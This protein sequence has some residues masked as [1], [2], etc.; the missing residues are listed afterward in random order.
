MILTREILKLVVRRPIIEVVRSRLFQL[1]ALGLALLAVVPAAATTIVPAADPG[2]LALDSE[3]VFLARAGVSRVVARPGYLATTTELEVVS[4]AKGSMSPGSVI[5]SIVPGGVKDG[6]GWVVAGAPKLES[7]KVYLFFAD[8]DPRGRW[9][10]RLMADSVLRQ[11]IAEDGSKVL[12]PLEEASHLSRVGSAGRD[13]PLVPG[14]VNEEEFIAAL[15]RRLDGKPGWDWAPL[16]RSGGSDLYAKDAPAGCV[17]M[18]HDAGDGRP[19]R[20]RLFDSGGTQSMA[21]DS[22]G[23]SSLSSGGFAQVQGA[24]ARWN[25]VT[26]T[27]VSVSYGG[28]SASPP[29]S[30]TDDTDIT[31]NAV[32]FDDPCNEMADLTGCSGTLAFGGPSFYSTTTYSWD[33]QQWHQAISWFVVVNN[34]AGN[35]LSLADY[36]LMLTHEM[37]HGLGFGHVSDP[38]AL[39]HANCC[40]PHNSLDISCT[41]YLYPTAASTP[42]PTRTPTRTATPSG[43]TPTPTPTPPPGTTP[44]RTPAPQPTATPTGAT[45]TP[46]PTPSDSRPSQVTVPVVIHGE[47]VEGTP[48]RSDVVV[49]NP[50]SSPQELRFI[51][52][53]SGKAAFSATK[54]LAGRATLL[55]EDLVADL[56]RAGDSRGPL[57]IEVLTPGSEAPVV[58]SRAY[59]ENPF[60]NLG[61]GLPADV[62]PS[63]DVVS[64]PG[65]FHDEAFRSNIAVTADNGHDVWATFELFRGMDDLVGGG[66]Q[67]LIGAGQ[68][69]QWSIQQLFKNQAR[70]GVPMTV[71]VSLSHPGIVNASMID[72]LSTDSA[73]FLGKV[74]AINWIVPVVAHI[75]GSDGTFWNSSVSLWNGSIWTSRIDL[76]YL[77]EKTD[78]SSGGIHASFIWLEPYETRTIEDV[79][80]DLFNIDDGKGVLVVKSTQVITVTSRVFTGGP[81]G[82]TSGNGVRTVRAVELSSEDAVL[83]GV[84]MLD[85]FR[86]NVGVVTSDLGAT[87]Q[88]DLRDAGGTLLATAFRSVEPRSLRQLSMEKLFGKN[89]AA[90]DPVGSIVISGEADFLAY[91]TVIDGTSQDPVFVMPQ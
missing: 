17:F 42:T 70:E 15:E 43:P 36:E 84:R 32:V 90:P 31:A 11:A 20:W 51:Y 71:R 12:V 6:I 25:G 58:V 16:V 53:T 23:D 33:S 48:W 78:N 68:Q 75:P 64:M 63:T 2:E 4:V 89:V 61:S 26:S 79:L 5:E 35:C 87:F 41:Q 27:S 39:M 69:D 73:V 9:Q 66:V 85:G 38:N 60:G 80:L 50:N 18:T 10:P 34:G 52:V 76:E 14:P 29:S 40:H 54:N 77:P 8:R 24:L 28:A 21:A 74:P 30:C 7:G 44:T 86:T 59:A 19:I 91:L 56:F 81:L 46:T 88:F 49:T 45:P 72:N 55:L 82:G 57:G 65:L 37:G 3:A 22:N 47:G 83:P 1:A 67:R 13:A 62:Q